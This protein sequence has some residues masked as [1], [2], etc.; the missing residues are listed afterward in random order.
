MFLAKRD[1]VRHEKRHDSLSSPRWNI[2]VS[3]TV[4]S[5]V[6]TAY[7]KLG[8][9]SSWKHKSGRKSEMK[10]GNRRVLKRLVGR[11]RKTAQP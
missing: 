11:K 2:R 4:V 5:N 8:K 7:T 6:M 1:H 9:V 3:R 10:V